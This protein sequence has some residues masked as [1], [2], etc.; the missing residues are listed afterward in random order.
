MQLDLPLGQPV[1]ARADEFLVSDVNARAVQH[2]EHWGSW[3]V[4]AALL[5][6]PRKSGRSLLARLFALRTGGAVVDDAERQ[7]EVDIFHAWNQAQAEHRPLLIVADAPPP[8]W[9]IRLPDL[10][11]RI[12]ATPVL[13]LGLPDA[14]LVASL[15][16][17]LFER[18]EIVAGPG[19]IDWI[20]RRVERS[21]ISILGVVEALEEDAM[22]RQNRRLSIATA[23]PVLTKAG[24]VPIGPAASMEHEGA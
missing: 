1:G 14:R 10:R 16:D 8:D 22:V 2:L 20:T 13:T 23:R 12:G 6:G 4:M 5:V 24:L 19:L 9:E 11:S 17:Y 7:G 3:P 15:L 18:R 21:Y